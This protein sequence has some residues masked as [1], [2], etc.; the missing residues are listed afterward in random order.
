[1]GLLVGNRT[2]SPIALGA[3]SS[4]EFDQ[5]ESGEQMP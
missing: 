5:Q 3:Q 2:M 1:M 4:A